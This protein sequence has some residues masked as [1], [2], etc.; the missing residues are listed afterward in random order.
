M[1]PFATMVLTVNAEAV[2]HKILNPIDIHSVCT[3]L[4]CATNPPET[5][6]A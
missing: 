4:C 5:R 3:I 2:T 1:V 6:R